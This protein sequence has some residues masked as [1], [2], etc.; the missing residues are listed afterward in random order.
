MSESQDLS[1]AERILGSTVA[2]MRVMTSQEFIEMCRE[3]EQSEKTSFAKDVFLGIEA[4]LGRGLLLDLVK[5][6]SAE[7]MAFAWDYNEELT[8]SYIGKFY[9]SLNGTR[10]SKLLE[11]LGDMYGGA[12]TRGG[13]ESQSSIL[14]EGTIDYFMVDL[15]ES[16][17]AG[18]RFAKFGLRVIATLFPIR[19]RRRV[20]RTLVLVTTFLNPKS[21]WRRSK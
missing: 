17:K 20:I 21:P 9:G 16:H 15:P 14:S 1:T 18:S 2:L 8:R 4:R 13:Q 12:S 19:T 10:T 3:L 6:I 7:S 5:L 11:A